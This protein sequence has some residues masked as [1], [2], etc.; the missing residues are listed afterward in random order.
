MMHR[1]QLCKAGN[2]SNSSCKGYISNLVLMV[3]TFIQTLYIYIYIYIFFFFFEKPNVI[4]FV[5]CSFQNPPNKVS[6]ALLYNKSSHAED[7]KKRNSK[8]PRPVKNQ[9]M[10]NRNARTCFER[11]TTLYL[12]INLL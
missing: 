2:I 1:F 4:F 3:H 12:L 7:K 5:F 9:Q 8:R 10:Q 6:C 11:K